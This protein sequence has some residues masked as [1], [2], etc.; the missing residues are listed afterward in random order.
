M[1]KE[2]S[3]MAT[4]TDTKDTTVASGSKLG[5]GAL[6]VTRILVGF[7]FLWAFI[8]KLIGL[9]FTTCR[10]KEEGSTAIDVMC[11]SAW[12]SGGKITKGYL[13][14]SS[15]PL[16]DV[17]VSL[18]DQRWTD[19]IF[20][21]GLLGIGLALML[22]IGTKIASW[23]GVA[24]LA[25]MYVSHAWPGAVVGTN[26]VVDYHVIYAVAGVAT[27]YVE[28]QRQSIGLGNWWR[29]LPIVQKNQWLV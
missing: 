18:G 21:I 20:M 15:G 1:I 25:M 19:W 9:G 3:S 2:F 12:L 6:S 29:K 16:E 17:F 7:I 26:P 10:S 5:W 22:G 8:D 27:V 23:C 24:M 11:D 14:S 28:L 13:G 4:T